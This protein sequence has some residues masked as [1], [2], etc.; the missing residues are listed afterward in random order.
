MK[1]YRINAITLRHL[2]LTFRDLHRFIELVYWPLLDIIIWGFTTQWIQKNQINTI[3]VSFILLTSLI[4][5]Q[6]IFR[7]QMEINF[8]LLDE[9][10][11]HN[12]TNLFSTP[13]HLSEWITSV[14]IIGFLKCLFTMGFGITAVWLL[15]S[16]N[17]FK[18][19][20]TI[21]YLFIISIISGWGIGFLTT[22]AI[23]YWGQKMQMLAW[24]VIW[25]FAPFS[26]V[27]YPIE[28][29]P[30]WV[31]K[32][33]AITPMSYLFEGIRSLITT[34]NIPYSMIICAFC[35]SLV[36]LLV[37][38]IIFKYAFEKTKIYGLARLERYE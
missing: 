11:S 26:G 24:T 3:Q 5:W 31:Q 29:L 32:I 30:S 12:L 15:Y 21:F 33:S 16:I 22:A 13:I 20:F 9:I 10:W 27:F 17:V 35:L 19:G 7:A 6:V 14:M 8:S 28:I 23:S 18:L 38:I 2:I 36:Y 1:L 37:S 4:F 25:F 34:G